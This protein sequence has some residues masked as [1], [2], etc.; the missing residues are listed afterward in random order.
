MT[1]TDPAPRLCGTVEGVE[2]WIRVP[3]GRHLRCVITESALHGHF[4]AEGDRPES[5]LDAFARH[6]RDIEGHALA[7]SARREDVHVVLVTDLEG[8]LR[9]SVGRCAS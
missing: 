1:H 2:F 7:A 9:A 3:C 8:R 5:W 4:G 6:R